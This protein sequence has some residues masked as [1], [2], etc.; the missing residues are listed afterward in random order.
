MTVQEW[1]G[2]TEQEWEEWMAEML[3]IHAGRIPPRGRAL[4]VRQLKEALADRPDDER[5]MLHIRARQD[6]GTGNLTAQEGGLLAVVS[7]THHSGEAT[8][9][10]AG[11]LNSEMGGGVA[12]RIFAKVP[13]DEDD[14]VFPMFRSIW[15]RPG[16]VLGYV[17]QPQ[18]DE[19]GAAPAESGAEEGASC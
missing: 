15:E 18:A 13:L 16:E 7:E 5:V 17:D 1:E 3:E 2:F 19:V 6:D 4:T 12:E 8:V 11:K 9:Y 14:Y 10:L